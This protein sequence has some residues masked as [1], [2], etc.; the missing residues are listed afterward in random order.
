[1]KNQNNPD[2]ISELNEMY[3]ICSPSVLVLL[4]SYFKIEWDEQEQYF[5]K[6]ESYLA[7]KYYWQF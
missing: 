6:A 3:C 2:D 7:I 1:M 5:F 4:A